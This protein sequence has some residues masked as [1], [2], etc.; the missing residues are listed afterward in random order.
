M[1]ILLLIAVV[2]PL[3]WPT[4][5]FTKLYQ[6]APQASSWIYSE[7]A[8]CIFLMGVVMDHFSNQQLHSYVRL[9][10]PDTWKVS[11]LM[12]YNVGAGIIMS[13]LNAIAYMSQ[14]VGIRTD[15]GMASGSFMIIVG[16]L[17]CGP[18]ILAAIA[19]GE[20]PKLN[21]QEGWPK[22][23]VLVKGAC[24]ALVF[25]IIW[26]IIGAAVVS[27]AALAGGVVPIS[28]IMDS[29]LDGTTTMQTSP[30][31]SKSAAHDTSLQTRIA[32]IVISTIAKNLDKAVA[33]VAKTE[34]S[35][36][37][38][39]GPCANTVPAVQAECSLTDI[40]NR[41][42][43]L[44]QVQRSNGLAGSYDLA[45]TIGNTNITSIDLTCPKGSMRYGGGA[46]LSNPELL[47]RGCDC[48]FATGGRTVCTCTY[49]IVTL[50]SCYLSKRKCAS[51]P[52]CWIL[53]SKYC[54]VMNQSD[55]CKGV[56]IWTDVVGSVGDTTVQVLCQV[57]AY[58]WLPE[59]GGAQGE[60]NQGSLQATQTD[61]GGMTWTGCISV[62]LQVKL[63][64]ACAMGYPAA[65]SDG[66]FSCM[67]ATESLWDDTLVCESAFVQD[68]QS[69]TCTET[70]AN[71]PSEKYNQFISS[72]C[73]N[74]VYV[75][76]Q[77][78][79]VQTLYKIQGYQNNICDVS[80]P[81]WYVPDVATTLLK[82]V[83]FFGLYLYISIS[84]NTS[85]VARVLAGNL[86][87]DSGPGQGPNMAELVIVE[88]Q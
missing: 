15:F 40:V 25:A 16:W 83:L 23:K 43:T 67:P 50:S 63:A 42:F 37:P 79:G 41:K 66:S 21:P 76:D 19:I 70:F 38:V 55:P 5:L 52:S 18:V 34:S 22:P 31:S 74:N 88:K 78:H 80:S 45:L 1:S 48:Q 75:T 53:H 73:R 82:V 51:D 72:S 65:S 69:P 10:G 58:Q 27:T 68:L 86:Y 62:N 11:I 3:I 20:R 12:L 33:F 84:R 26:L 17:L 39:Q 61:E 36:F 30:W 81:N 85:E 35:L 7:T 46:C 8:L 54:A 6:S 71:R 14:N 47:T 87:D 24:C 29:V 9:I 59:T 49:T 2:S 32:C 57:A 44:F 28:Y 60:C 4:I 56:G 13:C 64:I 77:N